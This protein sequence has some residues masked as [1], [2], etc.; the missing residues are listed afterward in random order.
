MTGASPVELAYEPVNLGPAHKR[1]SCTRTATRVPVGTPT[2]VATTDASWTAEAAL[3]PGSGVA[4]GGQVVGGGLRQRGLPVLVD[5]GKVPLLDRPRG[6]A[7]RLASA[8]AVVAWHEA[9][10]EGE[11]DSESPPC[12]RRAAHA[13]QH[14]HKSTSRIRW[15]Y[16]R[17]APAPDMRWPN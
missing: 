7:L 9:L 6:D 2:R 15:S 1:T 16:C 5:D 11:A 4:G 8:V 3:A 13:A 17:A 10:R 12:S 14:A